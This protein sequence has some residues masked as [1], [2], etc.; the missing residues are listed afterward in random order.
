MPPRSRHWSDLTTTDF[1]ALDPVKTVAVLPVGATEQHGPHLPLAV[2]RQ[3]QDPVSILNLTRRL[4]AMRKAHPALHIGSV[5]KI[6]V[7][8]PLLAFEREGDGERLLCVFNL[9]SEA[10]EWPLPVGWRIITSVG[11][12][13][14]PAS[15]FIAE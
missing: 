8:A 13:L 14:D 2:D 6:D 12:D 1:A 3:E 15:G 7:P 9:G 11:T 4:V 10:A 5:R